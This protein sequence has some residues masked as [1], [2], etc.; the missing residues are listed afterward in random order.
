MTQPQ[1]SEIT[2]IIEENGGSKIT[3]I[4]II[5]KTYGLGLKEAKELVDEAFVELAAL[6]PNRY[7]AK[8]GCFGLILFLI[9]LS[10]GWK[11]LSL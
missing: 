8:K 5:R 7:P 11:L 6:D 2:K 1:K 10:F 4:K 3:S 9:G